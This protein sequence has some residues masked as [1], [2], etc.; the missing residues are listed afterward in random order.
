MIL[1]YVELI[2]VV[3]AR[4]IFAMNGVYRP[5]LTM[6]A[7]PAY[8][9]TRHHV[10]GILRQYAQPPMAVY[11]QRNCVMS[12]VIHSIRIIN[13]QWDYVAIRRRVDGTVMTIVR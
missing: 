1:V 11:V 2:M 12:G 9:V 5:I 3:H 4:G 13:V 6:N 7:T 8:V 10:E